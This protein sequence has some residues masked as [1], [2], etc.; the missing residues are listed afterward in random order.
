MSQ[1]G[2]RAAGNLDDL[3]AEV[4]QLI[5]ANLTEQ[6]ARR[7]LTVREA[8]AYLS[9]SDDSVRA[10][11]AVGRLTARR[12]VPGRV[13]IDRRELDF[14]VFGSTAKP[15]HGRG[16]RRPPKPTTDG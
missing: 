13:L 1:F 12:P 14:I 15:V 3:A 6:N 16:I 4:A 8:A 9:L 5:A 11:L 7:W 10:M 2:N